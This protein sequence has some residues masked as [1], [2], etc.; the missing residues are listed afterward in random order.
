[1]VDYY[2]RTQE[3]KRRRRKFEKKENRQDRQTRLKQQRL[4]NKGAMNRTRLSQNKQTERTEKKLD[5]KKNKWKEDRRDKAVQSQSDKY[6]MDRI[7][8]GQLHP[9]YA[10]K[11]SEQAQ[12]Q[13]MMQRPDLFPGADVSG[14]GGGS[15]GGGGGGGVGGLSGSKVQSVWEDSLADAG[16]ELKGMES[17]G[18]LQQY[19][20]QTQV[21]ED[22]DQVKYVDQRGEEIPVQDVKNRIARR[23]YM[24]RMQPPGMAFGATSGGG[25]QQTGA[26]NWQQIEQDMKARDVANQQNLRENLVTSYVDEQGNPVDASKVQEADG[27]G[28]HYGTLPDGTKAYRKFSLSGTG[29]E[30]PTATGSAPAEKSVASVGFGEGQRDVTGQTDE[31]R[32]AIDRVF[33]GDEARAARRQKLESKNQN[34]AEASPGAAG[35]EKGARQ[36]TSKKEKGQGQNQAAGQAQKGS[37]RRRIGNADATSPGY[38][39]D[40]EDFKAWGEGARDA[41][42]HG[43]VP[44]AQTFN[45]MTWR[46]IWNASKKLMGAATE[47]QRKTREKLPAYGGQKGGG[48]DVDQVA[49]ALRKAGLGKNSKSLKKTAQELRKQYPNASI[50]ELVKMVK[51][52]ASK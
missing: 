31:I 50:D 39:I 45:D 16:E 49:A 8:S 36:K 30:T 9:K 43:M 22:T 44:A 12:E 51:Q 19:G 17:A 3:S 47:S 34:Q 20:I 40:V 25:Q 41:Y 4:R 11:M 32:G 6:Y 48:G 28:Q 5:F 52:S 14:G 35:T 46:P 27:E 7:G 13:L 26:Q 42:R 23:K 15:S 38:P 1:M 21:D 37:A 24:T 33:A 2:E 10:T 29:T 18:S